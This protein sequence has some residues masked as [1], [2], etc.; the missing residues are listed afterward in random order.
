[1]C[2]AGRFDFRWRWRP[3]G[4]TLLSDAQSSRRETAL[5]SSRVSAATPLW[6]CGED[7]LWLTFN[8]A[9]VWLHPPRPT[10]AP[11]HY[12]PKAFTRQSSSELHC[13]A[14]RQTIVIW[15]PSQ[16]GPTARIRFA[17]HRLNGSS[18]PVLTATCLSYGSFCDS[19]FFSGTR[20][21]VRRPNRSS[22][23]MAQMTW[24]RA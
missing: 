2:T 8:A 5:L 15:L 4:K 24:I 3:M 23:K 21:G 13:I 9:S 12:S 10:R 19:Y 18:S 7:V 16:A 11:S 6:K 22:R 1:M 20:L 17:Y 14:S